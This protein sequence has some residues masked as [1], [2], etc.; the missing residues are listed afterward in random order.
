MMDHYDT[1]TLHY[2]TLIPFHYMTMVWYGMVWYGMVWYGIPGY[3]MLCYAMLCHA[4]LCY[5]M[6]RYAQCFIVIVLPRCAIH[7]KGRLQCWDLE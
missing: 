7:G 2:T 3:F 4:I 5:A 1:S 6:L